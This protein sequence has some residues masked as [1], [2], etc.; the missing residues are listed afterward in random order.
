MLWS[1]TGIAEKYGAR[2]RGPATRAGSMSS[3]KTTRFHQTTILRGGIDFTIDFTN[4]KEGLTQPFYGQ[5]GGFAYGKMEISPPSQE[6]KDGQLVWSLSWRLLRKPLILAFCTWRMRSSLE[7]WWEDDVLLGNGL[8]G[9]WGFG[10]EISKVVD[11]IP[12]VWMLSYD[13]HKAPWISRFHPMWPWL[14]NGWHP[15]N[16]INR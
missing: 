3:R 10:F 7:K 11:K 15:S 4:P 6:G 13:L 2:S 14:A 8:V 9:F 16:P 5:N 1:A 12:G